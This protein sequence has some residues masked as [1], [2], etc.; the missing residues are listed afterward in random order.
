VCGVGIG[1]GDS[2]IGERCVFVRCGGVVN[3]RF[4]PVVGEAALFVP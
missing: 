2:G 3:V 4:V 1:V